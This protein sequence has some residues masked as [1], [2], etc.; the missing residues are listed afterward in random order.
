MTDFTMPSLGADME[1]AEVVKWLVRPGQEVH[2]GDIVAVVETQKG[3]IDVEIF[4]E[5]IVAELVAAEG[6][7]VPVGGLLARISPARGAAAPPPPPAPPPPQQHPPLPAPPPNTPTPS[8]GRVKVSPA[9]RRRAAELGI[10]PETLPGT[11][12]DGAVS[13]A[14]VE[15]ARMAG[16]KPA[17]A[18]RPARQGGFDPAEMRRAIAAAMTR[19]KREVPHYYLSSTIDMGAALDWLAAYNAPRPPDQRMLPAVLMLKAAALALR[20]V[21]GLNGFWQGDGFQPAAGVHIGWAISL[22]GGGLVAPAIHDVDRLALPDL[23]ARLRDLV[24]RARTGGLRSSELM[25]ATATITSLGERGAD[26]VTGVIY[27]PQVAILGF[28]R[29]RER[30]WVV[31]GQI[32]VRPLVEVSLAADHRASDGHAGGLLLSALENALQE[33]E[34]L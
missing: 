34:Q 31:D 9:A 15:L 6:D 30:P 3:A 8:T 14:D 23:M 24:A 26:A 1:S 20:K 32:A 10:A 13:Y 22:R 11:G 16:A 17:P 4:T 33:P 28:G 29:V 12:V 18:Q 21:P 5:G 27:P 2:R 19:S 25:D 7:T